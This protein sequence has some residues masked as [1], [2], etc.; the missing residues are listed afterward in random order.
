M[1]NLNLLFSV[2]TLLMMATGCGGGGGGFAPVAET[3]APQV[4][5]YYPDPNVDGNATSADIQANG[6]KVIFDEGMSS[7]SIT[8]ASFKV[9]E[10]NAGGA[11]VSGTVTYDES[12]RTAKFIPDTALATSWDYVVT[13]TTAVTDLAGNNLAVTQTWSFMVAAAAP[14]GGGVP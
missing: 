8:S 5:S 7:A 12:V 13:I 9:E 3:T 1:K 11:A 10:W 2:L 6:I 14:P 4:E